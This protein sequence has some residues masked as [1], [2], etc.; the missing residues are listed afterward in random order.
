M[1]NYA[2]NLIYLANYTSDL[3][4]VTDADWLAQLPIFIETG[5]KRIL[6]DLD[7]L[8]SYVTDT[9]ASLQPNNRMFNL[10]NGQG[11][12]QAV[13]TVALRMDYQQL[14][15]GTLFTQPPLL[16]TSKEFLEAAYPD[17]HA[18]GAPSIPQYVAPVTD[19]LYAV[20]PTAGFAYP[21]VIYGQIYPTGLS[22]GN[23]ETFISVNMAEVL[24][25][26]EMIAVALWLKQFGQQA[27][28]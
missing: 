12:F 22:A 2:E 17:D 5:E 11:K 21:L 3:G 9:T 20:G 13:A 27:D 4:Y 28:E 8:S 25:A 1:M 7:M 18:V 23:I 6:R 15:V 26:S 24:L 16:C 10:P 19:N 14:I